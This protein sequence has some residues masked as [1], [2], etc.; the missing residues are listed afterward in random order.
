M[1]CKESYV[2][3]RCSKI[4]S[5]DP[6]VREPCT[7]ELGM[8]LEQRLAEEAEVSSRVEKMSKSKG[9][10]VTFDEVIS[11]YG[12]DTLRLY[13]LAIGPPQKDAEWQDS[14][15]VGY[16]RFLNRL[17]DLVVGYQDAFQRVAPRAV[18]AARLDGLWADVHRRVH[19]TT[20]KVTRD[21]EERWRFNTAIAAVI[22]LLNDV[23]KL[24]L[25]ESYG[26]GDGDDALGEFALLRFAAER[27]VQLVA[28]FVPHFAEEL[29]TRLGHEPSIFEHGWPEWDEELAKAEEVEVPVQVNGRVRD[30]LV[31]ERD[32]DEETVREMALELE[33]VQRHVEGREIR[34]VIVVPNRIVNVVVG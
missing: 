11:E 19:A 2:C 25:R 4:V 7:C 29:W 8:S 31:V 13:T 34:R 16:S 27:I 6:N 14:G 17:W 22:S 24:P 32:E 15:I 12:C 1:I 18:D 20:K 10:V 26:E 23:Q 5:D 21:I 30:R 33:N 28:P 3:S 9:N